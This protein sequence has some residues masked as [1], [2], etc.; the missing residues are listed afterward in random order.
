MLAETV[1]A[2]PIEFIPVSSEADSRSES[3]ELVRKAQDGDREAF[4]MLYEKY[5]RH[6]MS[7]ALRRLGNFDD[8]ED[9]KLDVFIQAREKLSSLRDPEAFAGWLRSITNRMAIN[10]LIR[11]KRHV[12]LNEFRNEDGHEFFPS[13]LIDRNEPIHN[14]IQNERNKIVRQAQ[15]NL[16]AID[17]TAIKDYYYD[18]LSI[19]DAAA[20]R[21]APEGTIKRR[22]HVGRKRLRAEI[23]RK[24]PEFSVE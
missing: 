18:D 24:Y 1:E 3:A 8:S 15:K 11:N 4:G 5:E 20:K 9:L 2:E 6:V 10:K 13:E 21:E 12:S 7:V 19:S 16:G 23:L 17:K 14:L 22:M